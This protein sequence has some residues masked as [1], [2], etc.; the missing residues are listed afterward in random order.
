MSLSRVR[1]PQNFRREAGPYQICAGQLEA[2]IT[3]T[4]THTHTHLENTQMPCPGIQ[5]SAPAQVTSNPLTLI[6]LGNTIQAPQKCF[7]TSFRLSP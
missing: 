6:L 1:V 3:H 7:S 2:A 5:R 4:H